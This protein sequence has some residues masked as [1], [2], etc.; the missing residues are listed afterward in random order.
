MDAC[1]TD[2]A[3]EA[4]RFKRERI[5]KGAEAKIAGENGARPVRIN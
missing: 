2:Y 4:T 3:G 5:R 1:W